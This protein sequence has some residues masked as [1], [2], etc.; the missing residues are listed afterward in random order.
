MNRRHE[1]VLREEDNNEHMVE[2]FDDMGS[3]GESVSAF[4]Q[5][6]WN[7]EQT[8]LV[9]ARPQTWGVISRRLA[10]SGWATSEAVATGRLVVLDAAVALATVLQDRHPVAHAF[11]DSLGTLVRRLSGQS[12]A[13]CVYGEMM[14]L[15][16]AEGEFD[17]AV[18]LEHLWSEL[19]AQCPFTLLCGYSSAHFADPCTDAAL[20]AICHK[21]HRASAKPTDLLGSWLLSERRPRYHADVTGA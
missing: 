11:D 3:A 7:R 6:G 13:L 15:L 9:V 19:A 21:H 1:R 16:A 5:A 20:R 18:E 14:D 8:L 17:A 2:L 10:E 12:K 4:L